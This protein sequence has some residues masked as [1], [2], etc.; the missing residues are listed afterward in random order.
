MHES[1]TC[2]ITNKGVGEMRNCAPR[3]KVTNGGH[4]RS[5]QS[6][7]SHTAGKLVI[8]FKDSLHEN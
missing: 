7:T 3:S 2:G 1:T 4:E 8:I 5:P 6:L